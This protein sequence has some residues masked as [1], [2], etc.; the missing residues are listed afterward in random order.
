MS[1]ARGKGTPS[2]ILY[3]PGTGMPMVFP[4]SKVTLPIVAISNPA[5]ALRVICTGNHGAS[6]A[7]PYGARSNPGAH[8]VKS[9]HYGD[10]QPN[11]VWAQLHAEQFLKSTCTR[12]VYEV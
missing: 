10:A 9:R 3:R 11:P 2:S 8:L 5:L 12:M 1:P 6:R 4:D 7:Y